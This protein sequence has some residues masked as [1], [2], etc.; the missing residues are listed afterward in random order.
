M[1]RSVLFWESWE[2]TILLCGWRR[3]KQLPVSGVIRILYAHWSTFRRECWESQTRI[4]SN[5]GAGARVMWSLI[6][7]DRE[8][9]SF[10]CNLT[11]VLVHL[12]FTTPERDIN[13]QLELPHFPAVHCYSQIRMQ[14]GV[15]KRHRSQVLTFLSWCWVLLR[16]GLLAKDILG[17]KFFCSVNSCC[18]WVRK[19]APNVVMLWSL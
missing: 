12:N 4:P 18:S 3:E 17:N 10:S 9:I 6:W 19:T 11:L 16:L 5:P 15:L 7:S 14:M 13:L 8:G 1:Q 2:A